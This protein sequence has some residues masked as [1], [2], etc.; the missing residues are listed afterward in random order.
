MTTKKTMVPLMR[1]VTSDGRVEPVY[2]SEHCWHAQVMNDRERASIS[3]NGETWCVECVDYRG[4][5]LK[6]WVEL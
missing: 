6:V 1:P 3:E 4:E 2:V 5:W